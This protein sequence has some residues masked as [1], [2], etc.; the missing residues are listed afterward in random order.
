MNNLQK[1]RKFKRL[2]AWLMILALLISAAPF[3]FAAG[4]AN[5]G[6]AELDQPLN[7]FLGIFFGLLRVVGVIVV[8]IGIIQFVASLSGHDPTQK[9]TSGLMIGGGL[10]VVFLKEILRAMG[11]I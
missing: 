5:T 6:V 11:I 8:I 2:A 10:I 4:I 1:N 3:C 9:I 7:N